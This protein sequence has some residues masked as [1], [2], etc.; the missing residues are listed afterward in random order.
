[1]YKFSYYYDYNHGRDFVEVG[2]EGRKEGGRGRGKTGV[3]WPSFGCAEYR[4]RSGL[5]C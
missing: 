3:V 2:E 5:H 1:M 4:C